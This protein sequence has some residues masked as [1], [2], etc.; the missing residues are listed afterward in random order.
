MNG[1]LA[2]LDAIDWSGVTDCYGVVDELPTLLRATLSRDGEEQRSALMDARN[3]VNHQGDVCEASAHIVPFL[4]AAAL[5]DANRREAFVYWLAWSCERAEEVERDRTG[6]L[7]KVRA[8]AAVELP[9]LIGLLDDPDP[10][11]RRAMLMLIAA[12]PHEI[13]SHLINLPTLIDPDPL[14]R[15]DLL[16]VVAHLQPQ[17]SGLGGWLA[18]AQHDEDPRVAYQAIRVL[19]RVCGVPFP[20][21]LVDALADL[22]ADHG[23]P[24]GRDELDAIEDFCGVPGTRWPAVKE[25][26]QLRADPLVQ[27]PDAAVHAAR[28][29]ARSA[30]PHVRYALTLAGEID[31]EWRGREPETVPLALAA[32]PA[33]TATKTQYEALRWIARM[34]A[35]LEEPGQEVLTSLQ[36]WG[37]HTDPTLAA[38][39]WAASAHVDKQ[40]TA[41]RLGPGAD[42]S[43][44]PLDVLRE[45]CQIYGPDGDFL[46]PELRRRLNKLSQAQPAR[47]TAEL[48]SVIP[49][50]GPGAR[51]FL[52]TLH[53]M[54]EQSQN[55]YILIE[56]LGALGHQASESAGLI[57]AVARTHDRPH[58]RLRAARAHRAITGQ[59]TLA[60]H[61]AAEVAEAGSLDHW[62]IE[63]VGL[64]GPDAQACTDLLEAQRAGQS[65]YP[66]NVL[67]ALWRTTHDR[68][69]YAPHLA[70]MARSSSDAIAA[71]QCLLKIGHCPDE[72]RPAIT[73]YAE[74]RERILYPTSRQPPHK[75]DYLLQRLARELLSSGATSTR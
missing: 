9:A 42:L 31:Q 4:A 19:M 48:I 29:L 35:V 62:S 10:R 16:T 8:A 50:L 56:T 30:S 12:F 54:L 60:R 58:F 68:E 3:Q 22:I 45:L 71:I 53:A 69:K 33:I 70:A 24:D 59:H 21:H 28:R 27:D 46:I 5:S 34:L 51:E 72:C 15:A 66:A 36:A 14:V 11:V 25:H 26:V 41:E 61:V 2:V 7:V 40:S 67:I 39:A 52:P 37:D 23:L 32:L 75:G 43:R 13:T 64:L 1:P 44:V 49:Y 73:R 57:E 38:A 17:W 47:G 65:R 18:A 74:S 20:A 63:A 55:P 6:L